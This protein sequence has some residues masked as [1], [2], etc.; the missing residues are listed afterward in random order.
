MVRSAAMTLRW[1]PRLFLRFPRHLPKRIRKPRFGATTSW[2]CSLQGV[3]DG[4]PFFRNILTASTPICARAA[5]EQDRRR[6]R[7]CSSRGEIEDCRAGKG[8]SRRTGGEAGRTSQGRCRSQSSRGSPHH[9]RK[10]HPHRTREGCGCRSRAARCR[11]S[12]RQLGSA[13]KQRKKPP[14]VWFDSQHAHASRVRT[15]PGAAGA[16]GI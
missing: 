13:I 3:T 14:A 2:R 7:A 16:K 10:S 15:D 8:A 5:A 4:K 1:F 6:R 12:E 11:K 9:C